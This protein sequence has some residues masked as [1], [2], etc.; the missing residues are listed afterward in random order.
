MIYSEKLAFSIVS[1]SKLNDVKVD[2]K[3]NAVLNF[4]KAFYSYLIYYHKI[5][6]VNLI[7][8][9]ATSAKNLINY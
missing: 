5:S 4:L 7:K 2:L 1:Q 6:S 3:I 8:G 9:T